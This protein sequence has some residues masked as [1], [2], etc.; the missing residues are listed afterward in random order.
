M[1]D[2]LKHSVIKPVSL[3]FLRKSA[4]VCLCPTGPASTSVRRHCCLYLEKSVAIFA[5]HHRAT[6]KCQ[7]LC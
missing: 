3:A 4:R 1:N 2:S 7:L 5:A 6:Q